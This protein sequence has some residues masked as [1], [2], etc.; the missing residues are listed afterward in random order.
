[1]RITDNDIRWIRARG[2]C[3][4]CHHKNL[5]R[6][7]KR[8]RP[9]TRKPLKVIKINPEGSRESLNLIALCSPCIR[10][11]EW[12]KHVKEQ[13]RKAA[14]LEDKRTGQRSIFA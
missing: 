12:Q 14:E 8:G 5:L 11:F 7:S 6:H 4:N 10:I 9:L 13:N 2:F 3:E 1:M